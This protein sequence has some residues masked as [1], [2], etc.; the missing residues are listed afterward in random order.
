MSA[1]EPAVP[2]ALAE[3]FVVPPR[4]SSERR[5]RPSMCSSRS[6]L[7]PRGFRAGV[8]LQNV[9]R[10]T[11]GIFLLLV[12]VF[13]WT[14]SNFLASVCRYLPQHGPELTQAVHFRR[15]YIFEAI[16]RYIHQ[17]IFLCHIAHPNL[18]A[19]STPAWLCS[20]Q[21]LIAGIL[22]R[23]D[24]RLQRHWGEVDDGRRS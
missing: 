16:L 5:D 7:K 15:Q 20:H 24:G 17:Y 9:A 21:N 4:R 23:A 11:L 22:A 18:P 10:R 19:F 2:A 1:Q 8:G 14:S 13:L 12:T 3:E 6:A